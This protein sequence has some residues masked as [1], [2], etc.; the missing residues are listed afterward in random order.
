MFETELL[1]NSGPSFTFLFTGARCGF[2][3]W[4]PTLYV[5]VSCFIATHYRTAESV[6]QF[7][8]AD[9]EYTLCPWRSPKKMKIKGCEVGWPWRDRIRDAVMSVDEAV[10]R[11][12]WGEIAF[13]WD[14][15]C[16]VSGSHIEHPRTKTWMLGHC[17]GVIR[18]P[19]CDP[20]QNLHAF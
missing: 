12:V 5:I 18:F 4:Y 6:P 16:I 17:C 19:I 1:W 11:R 20:N 7:L 9:E 8:E 15:C 3:G 14:V 10:L 2:H 13:R